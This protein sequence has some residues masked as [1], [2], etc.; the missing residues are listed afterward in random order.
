[1]AI[2][3]LTASAADNLVGAANVVDQFQLNTPG[4][5]V[6]TDTIQG[7]AGSVI[8]TLRITAAMSLA[9][10][11]FTNVRGIERVQ[12]TTNIGVDLVLGNLMVTSTNRANFQ[13]LGGAGDDTVLGGAVVSRALLLDGG[14][15]ADGMEGGGGAD[16][17]R[18][19]SGADTMHGG[20]G[21]DTLE[22]AVGDLGANDRLDGGADSD[23]LRLLDGGVVSQAMFGA[24]QG[25]E[26][27]EV[28]PEATALR[29]TVAQGY[30]IEGDTLTIQGG[31]GDDTLIAVNAGFATY[32]LGLGGDDQLTGGGFGDTLLGD[33]GQDTLRG[34]A[35]DD[36]LD[37]GDGDDRLAGGDGHDWL[38]GGAG[39][40]VLSGGAGADTLDLGS[41]TDRADGGGG[42]DLYRVALIDVSSTDLIADSAGSAD[43]LV[44]TGRGSLLVTGV[45]ANRIL[46]IEH[47][48]FGAGN[49]TLM[50]G[51][52]IGDSAGAGV[53]TLE[54]G[55]GN[56]LLNV[57]GV[58]RLTTPLAFLL[59]GGEGN[60]SLLGG[61]GADTLAGGAGI[62]FLSGG[63]G[64]DL[65][66]VEA[67][68]LSAAST[69]VGGA[70]VDAL[71]FVGDAP[72]LA[73]ALAG[74][75]EVEVLELDDS[76]QEITVPNALALGLGFTAMTIRGGDGDDR[77]DI[78]GFAAGRR[79]TVELG[80]GDDVLIGGAGN[81]SISAGGG[82]D[83]IRV[84]GGANRVT[85]GV[86]E[87]SALDIVQ[88]SAVDAL[89]TL[90]IGI[91]A[92]QTLPQSAFL[93]V[94]GFDVINLAGEAGT[95]ARLAANLLTQSG[96]AS[97]NVNVVGQGM[98]VDGRDV[99]GAMRMDG[100]SGADVLFG[101][102]SAD[103]L[104]GNGGEDTLIGGPGGDRI[105][106]GTATERN[107]ALIRAASD[108]TADI[109][110]TVST[111]GADSVSGTEFADNFIMVDATAFALASATTFFIN[112]GQNIDIGFSAAV[113][114]TQYEIAGDAFGS[115][116]AV[117]N[118]VGARLTGNDPA[119]FEAIILAIG[120]A[121]GTRFGVYYFEDRD[122]NTTVDSADILRLLA[123]GTGDVPVFGA[124]NGFRLTSEF[125]IG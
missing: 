43:R 86:G 68:A 25:F 83:D 66:L 96:Q 19:G 57:A 45:V 123:I 121:S 53:V 22:M 100:G 3:T 119:E 80:D 6:P 34:L 67:E 87:L 17:L 120:G 108:G 32:L 40:D 11:A 73:A 97:I 69:L 82:V 113:L 5:L 21:N 24:L 64:N 105:F 104:I 50:V 70:G 92:G 98:V 39:N 38:L 81:D 89:D 71:R 125:D 88:A 8:D 58:A 37:G 60:D 59:L 78:S 16:V 74:V 114:P 28:A 122:H 13:V 35:G 116:T 76:G 109:N 99:S 106:L 124:G 65:L 61:Q 18:P 75:A 95:A 52:A 103:T 47:F 12:I 20:A 2:Y 41:G 30:G 1:M 36:V 48:L 33:A 31:A 107:V 4:H 23:V 29:L 77:V 102:A 101:G 55:A 44:F 26:R 84:G 54:G 62:T 10:V 118:A 110:T 112:N 93:G 49:D 111:A 9:A 14:S 94:S 72:I 51:N 117:R 85:F 46:G 27:I 91:G 42:D 56:D 63:A 15:G 79:V 90:V 7:G 115:L